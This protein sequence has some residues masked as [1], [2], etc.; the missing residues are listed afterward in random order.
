MKNICFNRKVAGIIHAKNFKALSNNS[1][2]KIKKKERK[3]RMKE[4]D[5][6]REKH[7]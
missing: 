3:I 1:S 4:K 7:F 6:E 5:L 2:K